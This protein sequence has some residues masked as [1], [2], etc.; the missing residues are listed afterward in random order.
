MSRVVMALSAVFWGAVIGGFGSWATVGFS[1]LAVA[2]LSLLFF[3]GAEL[4]YRNRDKLSDDRLEQVEER[5]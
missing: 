4:L 1:P 5:M 3:G 2:V